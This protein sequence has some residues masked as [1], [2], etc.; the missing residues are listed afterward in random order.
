MFEILS[1]NVGKPTPFEH[2]RPKVTGIF[3]KPVAGAVEIGPNGL[4][5]DHIC[6]IEAHGSPDQVVYLY[7]QPD[8]DYWIER[9]NRS[10][11]SGTFGENLLLAGFESASINVGDRFTLGPLVLEATAPR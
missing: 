7:G 8:Y 11:P 9:L 5:G 1:V 3:K 4:D 6:D 10:L 2:T